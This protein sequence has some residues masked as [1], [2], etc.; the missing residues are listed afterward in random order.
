MFKEGAEKARLTHETGKKQIRSF[1]LT[2]YI[3]HRSTQEID[4]EAYW[5]D[6]I[7]SFQ[8]YSSDRYTCLI[9]RPFEEMVAM[10][11]VVPLNA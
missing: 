8:P 1:R 11:K 5:L 3:V 2:H 4:E 10:W 7:E 6:Q 9:N